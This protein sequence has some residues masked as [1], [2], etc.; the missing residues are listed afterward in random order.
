MSKKQVFYVILIAFFVGAAGSIVFGRFLIPY[1][2]TFPGFSSLNQLVST[3]PIVINRHEEVQLNEGVNMI[4]LIKNSGNIT[5]SIYGPSVSAPQFLGDGVVMSADGLIFTTTEVVGENTT[6]Q[7][8]LNDGSVHEGLV[9]AT[10]RKT[11]LAILT[12]EAS[13]LQGAQFAPAQDLQSGQRVIVTGQANA[14]FN[15]A[16]ATGFVTSTAANSANLDKIYSSEFFGQNFSTD[17]SANPSI[18][19]GPVINL[20]GNVVGIFTSGGVID[21]EYIQSAL[22]TY[23]ASGKILRPYL[24]LRYLALSASMAAF[25]GLPQAGALVVSTQKGSPAASVLLP[26]DLIVGVNGQDLTSGGLDPILNTL[27]PGS[28]QL[29]VLRGGESMTIP[30]QLTS[31]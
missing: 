16:F 26:N 29:S 2:G 25:K 7:V 15:R 11:N 4:D 22:N 30:V 23:L 19:G 27:T 3:S 9:R 21:S 28:A 1:L 14:P 24:G 12:I 20:D 31:E 18:L 10:D 13:G 8:I 17:I 5:A 6:V